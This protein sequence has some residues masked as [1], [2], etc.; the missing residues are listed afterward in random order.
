MSAGRDFFDSL[1]YYWMPAKAALKQ[2]VPFC[3]EIVD[4]V[5]FLFHQFV[6]HLGAAADAPQ[7]W[8]DPGQLAPLLAHWDK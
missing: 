2:A 1:F 5:V 8:A 6:H 7:D 4:L 3:T